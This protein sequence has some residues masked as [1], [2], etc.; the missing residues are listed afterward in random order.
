VADPIYGTLFTLMAK[1]GLRPSEARGLKSDDIGWPTGSVWVERALES[2][3][4]EEPTKTYET[5]DIWVDR[6]DVGIAHGTRR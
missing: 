4:T 3:N 2:D 6:L 1:A 5:R